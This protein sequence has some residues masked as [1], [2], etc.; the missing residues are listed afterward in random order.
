MSNS[1]TDL[2]QRALRARARA[3]A[4]YSKFQVGAAIRVDGQVFEGVNVEN[5]SYPLCVCAERNAIAAAIDAG[6][7]HLE[8]VAVA[9]DASPPSSPCGACRQVLREFAPHPEQVT[10][11]AVNPRGERRSWTLAEL[12]PDSFSGKELP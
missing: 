5:A 6:A 12:L 10:V 1:S 9:T 8:E 11:T 3:Y 4:P 2:E 7:R